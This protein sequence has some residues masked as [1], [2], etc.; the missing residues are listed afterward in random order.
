MAVL[1]WIVCLGA[2]RPMAEGQVRCPTGAD[3]TATVQ[4]DVEDCLAC[5]YLMATAADRAPQF[6]CEVEWAAETD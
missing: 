6:M 5:R 3:S 2:E 1:D 4:V